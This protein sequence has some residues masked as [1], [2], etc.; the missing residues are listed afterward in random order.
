[1][2]V[3][4]PFGEYPF[5]FRRLERRGATVVVLGT[6][7]GVESGIVLDAADLRAAAKVTAAATALAAAVA[8][9]ARRA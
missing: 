9:L 7:A 4:S 8:L 2:K 3:I 6:V 5:Q 1:M